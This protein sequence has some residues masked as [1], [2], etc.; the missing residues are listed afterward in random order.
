MP[1]HA[2]LPLNNVLNRPKEDNLIQ[3][4]DKRGLLAHASYASESDTDSYVRDEVVPL[5][6]TE[7]QLRGISIVQWVSMG[8][9][10][11][12]T[13]WM[14]FSESAAEGYLEKAFTGNPTDC[15]RYFLSLI[16]SLTFVEEAY[17]E[18]GMHTYTRFSACVQPLVNCNKG[19]FPPLS[20]Y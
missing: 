2:W 8:S 16:L 18:N 14:T 7:E 3:Q 6:L 10:T 11:I 9:S 19:V 17:T 4:L 1:P 20:C 12:V 5:P 15:D 13:E